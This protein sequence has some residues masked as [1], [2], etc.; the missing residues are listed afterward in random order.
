MSEIL[1]GYLLYLAGI[2]CAVFGE[3]F[4]GLY[5]I[6]GAVAILFGSYMFDNIFLYAISGALAIMFF[7]RAMRR[8]DLF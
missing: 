3:V 6:I 8:K 7:F 2:F 4:A 5:Y 1:A